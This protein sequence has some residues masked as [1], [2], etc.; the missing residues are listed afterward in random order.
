[1]FPTYDADLYSDEGILNA[2]HHYKEIRDLGPV[3]RL[4]AT[5]AL[6]VGRYQDARYILQN[7]KKFI[8]SKGVALNE[9]TNDAAKGIPLTLD[10]PE[11]TRLKKVL[12][13]PLTRQAV[14]ALTDQMEQEADKLIERLVAQ[15]AF[16]GVEDLARALPVSIVST[17]VGLPEDGR[18][19]ML[20]WAAAS[21]DV[22][23]PVNPRTERG[24]ETF[25]GM[26]KYATETVTRDNVR[27]GSWAARIYDAADEGRITQDEISKLI[28]SYV[29]PSLETTISATSHMLHLFGLY[30]DQWRLLRENPDLIPNAIEE[31]LRV[32]T[33]VRSLARY[34]VEPV[35]IDGVVIPEGE[36]VVVL[37]ASANRDERKWREPEKFDITRSNARDHLAFG[38]GV[39]RCSGQYLAKLEI[40]SL[41]KAMASRIESFSVGE[42]AAPLN[43]ILSTMTKL[44]VRIQPDR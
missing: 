28:V 11:H 37:Y 5:G 25:Y 18:D 24:A 41:L 44:P 27:P 39:H 13:E 43:N 14:A 33:P 10:P 30:P 21:H 31:A 4:S 34:A 36:Y 22:N 35:E 42:S 40:T 38:L 2:Y 15:R 3:V 23:G 26:I 29:V 32:R 20:E 1:M 12:D 16:D 9:A 6:A 19:A 17:L 7:H 8:S